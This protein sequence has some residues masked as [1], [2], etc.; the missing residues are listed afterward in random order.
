M[1]PTPPE[2]LIL[3]VVQH[4]PPSS[5][6]ARPPRPPKTTQMVSTLSV[7]FCVAAGVVLLLERAQDDAGLA[8]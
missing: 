3:H 2:S 4:S 6:Q 5:P 8:L 7:L 1:P